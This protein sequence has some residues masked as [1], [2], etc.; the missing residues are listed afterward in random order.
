VTAPVLTA[1]VITPPA[2]TVTSGLTTKFTATGTYSDTS[3]ADI[4]SQVTW[5]TGNTGV[6]T[7]NTVP[8]VATGVSVGNTTVTASM[9][10]IASPAANLSV[11]APAPVITAISISPTTPSVPMGTPVIFTATGTF[12]NGSSG[13]ISGAVTWSSTNTAVATLNTTG[14]ASALTQGI[15]TVTASANGVTSNSAV[16]TVVAPIPFALKSG[17]VLVTDSH[18]NAIFAV[19]PLTGKQTLI[20]SILFDNFDGIVIEPSGNILVTSG[21]VIKR[22]N[23]VTFDVSTVWNAGNVGLGHLPDGIAVNSEGT[24]FVSGSKTIQLA[25]IS[26]EEPAIWRIDPITGVQ[27]LVTSG[28]YIDSQIS[29]LAVHPNGLLYATVYGGAQI[30]RLLEIDPNSGTQTKLTMSVFN[31]GAAAAS[32]EIDQ[33][34]NL[35]IPLETGADQVWRVDGS[36]Y[37]PTQIYFGGYD[38]TDVAV[39]FD[40]DVFVTVYE[41]FYQRSKLWRIDGQTG[42]ASILTYSNPFQLFTGVAV[43]P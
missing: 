43:V 18:E 38:V 12:S 16:L 36:T 40:G 28:G 10:G 33:Y 24:I 6:A 29:G 19:D 35:Y 42:N 37:I 15:T 22:I 41:Q 17:D 23:S 7:I 21:N 27:S 3:T 34:G 13:N 39:N 1:I 2:A 11:I 31:S 4:T 5:A 9:N 26:Y 20:A 8:G 32:I 30:T 14:V 25:N